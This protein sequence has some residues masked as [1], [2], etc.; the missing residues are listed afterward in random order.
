MTARARRRGGR[1]PGRRVHEWRYRP[2]IVVLERH[3]Q[4]LS[5]VPATTRRA[6]CLQVVRVKDER[7]ACA[8]IHHRMG[9]PSLVTVG[10]STRAHERCAAVLE[11]G[12]GGRFTTKRP[13][14]RAADESTS[15]PNE[16]KP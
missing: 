11:G 15:H 4:T 2:P 10:G 6:S 9:V 14:G 13:S 8:T 3:T 1:Q 5:G 12:P 16:A 7:R